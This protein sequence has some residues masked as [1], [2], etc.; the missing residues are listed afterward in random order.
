MSKKKKILAILLSAV[1]LCGAVFGI[2]KAVKKTTGG[3]TILVV[4]AGNFNYGGWYGS[5]NQ[6]EGIVTSD[7]SQDVYVSASDTIEQVLVSEGDRVRE[8]QVL[9]RYD[10]TKTSLALQRQELAYE[11]LKLNIEV[12]ERNVETLKKLRPYSDGGGGGYDP[13][14]PIPEPTKEPEI[15]AYKELNRG[16]S[17]YNAE[18]EDAGTESNPLRFLCTPDCVV[19]PAFMRAMK[20]EAVEEPLYFTLEVREENKKDGAIIRAF[21]FEA[22]QLPDVPDTWSGRLF[23]QEVIKESSLVERYGEQPAK[24]NLTG[25]ADAYNASDPSGT[26][27]SAENPYRFLVKDGTKISKSFIDALKAKGNAH[28][29]LE[30][31]TGNMLSG[32]LISMFYQSSEKVVLNGNWSGTVNLS[33]HTKPVIIVTGEV[34]PTPTETPTGTPTEA[35]TGTPT[36]TP[37]GTPTET[38]T[39]TPTEAPTGTPTEA[40]TETPT[41]APTETPTEAP[42]ETPTEAPTGTPTETPEPTEAPDTPVPP[43]TGDSAGGLSHTSASANDGSYSNAGGTT[44]YT[45]VLAGPDGSILN[46]AKFTRVAYGGG[47]D[48]GYDLSS[49]GLISPDSQYSKEDLAQARKDAD[50]T[51]RDYKLDLREAELRL[52]DARTADEEGEVKAKMDGMVKHVGDPENPVGDG[53]AFISVTG[54]G[55]QYVKCGLSELLLDEVHVGDPLSIMSWENGMTYEAVI[56]EISPYPDNSGMFGWGDSTATYYPLIAQINDEHAELT[57]NNWVQVTIMT[58]DGSEED[59]M[60]PESGSERELY[61]WKAFIL[62]EDN[63]KYV[64][65]QGEDGLLHKQE[66]KVGKLAGEGYQIISGVSPSDWIAFPYGKGVKEGAKTRQGSPDELYGY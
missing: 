29:V 53:S 8:G 32:S 33:D 46:G 2:A 16:S 38:P 36:E 30:S 66:I 61:L 37:T 19:T 9:I 23:L 6:M 22:S 13:V 5:D 4:E 56:K 1:L 17:P 10:R 47:G 31:R 18:E 55:G 39:G 20:K 45:T 15:T 43:A 57:N 44:T 27:G 11:Q 42:T 14:I 12:A 26:L 59:T 54:T 35:P 7:V 25:I 21:T 62:D 58:R 49:I 24:D 52:K 28:F 65:K 63:H 40:P 34:T 3:G 60:E 50:D 64:Y 41:E 48:N 51:L